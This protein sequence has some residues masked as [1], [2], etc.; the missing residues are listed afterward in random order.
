LIKTTFLFLALILLSFHTTGIAENGFKNFKQSSNGYVAGE[1]LVKFGKTVSD[2]SVQSTVQLFGD[3]AIEKPKHEKYVLVKL[4]PGKDVESAIAQYEGMP[5]VEYAQ[6]NF[7]YHEELTVPKDTY[8]ANLWGLKNTGQAIQNY[9]YSKNNPG[10]PGMDMDMEHAWDHVTDCSS[11]VLAVIDGGVNHTHEDLSGNMWNGAANHGYDFVDDDDDPVDLKGHGTHVAGTIGAVGNNSTGTT[12]VCW[13]IQIMAVRVLNALGRGTTADIIS[14][15]YYAVDN[16]AQ[17]LNLS[18]GSYYYDQA[19]YNALEY[20]RNN[21]VIV[22]ASAG[23]GDSNNDTQD[24]H[25]PSDYDLDNIISVAALDQ[26]YDL[27]SFSNYGKVSVDV[28]APGTNIQ[29]EWCGTESYISDTLNDGWTE[30]G[31][32]G[33]AYVVRDVGYG[34]EN[35][36]A[37]P[38]DIWSPTGGLYS[39]NADD[40]IWKTFNIDG[41]DVAR[42]SYWIWYDVENNFDYVYTYC[43]DGAS[44]PFSSGS[45][46]ARFTGYTGT[47]FTRARHII[48]SYCII[49]NCTIGFNLR[50]NSIVTG[51][52]AAV[53]D[54]RITAISL[55]NDSYDT[56]NGTSMAAPHVAGLAAMIWTFNPAY[57]YRE[58]IESVKN[59]GEP[60][61]SLYNKTVSGNA[62][63]A[64]GSLK[65]MKPP[66]GV[67]ISKNE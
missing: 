4:I 65:Y 41:Y 49:Q 11:I 39:N 40:R 59:G 53:V 46:L 20:A 54:F 33:W 10:T 66:T 21:D 8:Y 15:I 27:A 50:S 16:G 3:S 44:D 17:I 22:V 18:L 57:T 37:V 14:G 32:L 63:N 34:D 55:D 35:L 48:P 42:L 36:L 56:I 62:V 24:H 38:S 13:D 58:V 12:G 6:P 26:S 51:G 30:G 43:D 67:S 28:G 45:E 9:S 64:M 2:T 31:T 60:A 47:Y 19:F 52:G 29:S 61:S 5:H 1:I 7:I 23:N 25:Y